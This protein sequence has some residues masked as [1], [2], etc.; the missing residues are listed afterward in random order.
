[1]VAKCNWVSQNA[2]RLQKCNVVAKVQSFGDGVGVL[3]L[4]AVNLFDSYRFYGN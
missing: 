2:P 3:A 4:R 1:M